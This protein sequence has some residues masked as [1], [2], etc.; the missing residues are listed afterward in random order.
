MGIQFWD[1]VGVFSEISIWL[2][3]DFIDNIGFIEYPLQPTVIIKDLDFINNLDFIDILLTTNYSNNRDFTVSRYRKHGTN[4]NFLKSH[5]HFLFSFFSTHSWSF[6]QTKDSIDKVIPSSNALISGLRRRF[7]FRAP[8]P[9]ADQR[10]DFRK[11]HSIGKKQ[12]FGA[13]GSG[14]WT[15]RNEGES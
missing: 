4:L 1:L 10:K 3:L 7:R 15:R 13:E 6:Y 14:K 12:N 9:T 8:F 11:C 5:W 2:C